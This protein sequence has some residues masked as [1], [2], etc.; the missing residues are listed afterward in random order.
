MAALKAAGLGAVVVVGFDGSPDALASIKGGDMKATVLQ[1]A[2]AMARAA[3]DQAHQF[4]T[5][6]ST[7]KPEK[8]AIPCELVTK[9]NADQF[10]VFARK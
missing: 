5:T 7:G 9:A 1:P 10:G 6:Q 2:A 3:I 8:Q 4:L